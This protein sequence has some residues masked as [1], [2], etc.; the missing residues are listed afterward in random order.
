MRDVKTISTERILKSA[1]EFL[2]SGVRSS[3]VNRTTSFDTEP[4]SAW[5]GRSK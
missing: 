2:Q 4:V 1:R 3:I 5:G